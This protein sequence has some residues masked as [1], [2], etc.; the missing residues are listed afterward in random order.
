M[1]IMAAVQAVPGVEPPRRVKTFTRDAI[2]Y[3]LIAPPV[4]LMALLIF[5][6]IVQSL[7]RTMFTSADGEPSSFTLERYVAFFQD[8][9]S[10]SNLLFTFEIALITL[11]VLFIVCF[12]LAV[13]LRFSNIR[14]AAW[15]QVLTLFPLFVP[16]VVLAFALWRFL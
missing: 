5:F 11:I 13:Y 1:K 7:G 6:P 8:P 16:G 14:I 2:G 9:I 4:L 10:R 15:V 3:L 12:P